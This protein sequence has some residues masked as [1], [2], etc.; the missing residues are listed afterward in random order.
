[1]LETLEIRTDCCV[2]EAEYLRLLGFPRG[3]VP[4]GRVQELAAWARHWFAGNG[5]PWVYLREAAVQVEG[6]ALHIDGI[7]FDSPPLRELLA[8]A[9]SRRAVLAAISAGRACEEHAGKLWLE[10]KPD[11]YFFLEIFGS[12]VV[13]RLV[14]EASGRICD[15]AERE[16]L[17]AEPHY[18]PGYSGWDVADQNKLFELIARGRARPWPELLDVLPSGML[19][20]KKSLFAVFGLTDRGARAIAGPR[21]V[22]CARCSFSPCRYRRA[23]YRPGARGSRARRRLRLRVQAGIASAGWAPTNRA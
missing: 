9:G 19:R 17:M 8:G 21:P 5:R 14:A 12:A 10:S 6:D 18:S 13:E 20:P 1:M 16:G 3:Y 7:A 11:E 4:D 2:E 15:L 23:R 22:P